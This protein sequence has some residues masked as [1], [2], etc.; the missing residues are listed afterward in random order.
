MAQRGVTVSYE[1]IRTWCEKFGCQYSKK[2]RRKRGPMGETWHLDE[3]YLKIDG[4]QKY[5]WRAVDQEGQVLDI[6]V[7][8]KRNKLAAARFFKKVLRGTCQSP[9]EVVTDK[10][11]AYI[12]PCAR[13]LPS[14][15]HTRDKGANN[16]AENSHQP[17]RQRE[18]RMKRFKSAAHAQRFLSI[19]SEVGNL[20]AL[21]RHT[22]SA[23]NH[24][25]LLNKSLNT[26]SNLILDGEFQ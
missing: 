21:S 19:F 18:R 8:A 6:L 20:F 5:L 11:A 7:Q 13:V 15:A 24:R 1:S 25:L 26:W 17:T 3:V 23:T 16:R 14:S 10:L 9:R 12:Q 22:V 4:Q 2:I